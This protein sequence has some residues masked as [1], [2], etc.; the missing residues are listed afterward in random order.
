[1]IVGFIG[2]TFGLSAPLGFV[3]KHLIYKKANAIISNSRTGLEAYKVNSK[4]GMVIYNGF[5]QKRI[6]KFNSNKPTLSSLGINTTF[7][8]VMLANV[9]QHKDYNTFIKIAQKLTK[10]RNDITFL[11]VGKIK[12]EYNEMVAP[13]LN[14][15]CKQIKFIGFYSNPESI[16]QESDIGILCSYSEGISNAILE[17]MAVGL[18]VITTDTAGASKELVDNEIT[19]FICEKEQVLEKIDLLLSNINLRRKM[20]EK[21]RNRIQNSFSINKTL[22]K[23]IELYNNVI[24][25]NSKTS[26]A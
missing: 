10:K 11:S 14:N 18:P 6:K 20:G 16:L 17:Y 26:R 21:G 9:T 23:Y 12:P 3:A 4:K 22:I 15:K 24:N 1:M 25:E 7:T 8:I 2:D 19:G 13:Y 5:D